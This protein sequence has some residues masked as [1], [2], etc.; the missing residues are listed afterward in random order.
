MTV[1]RP[2]AKPR[3]GRELV[4]AAFFGPV[5]DRLA[6][7]LA[8][9]RVPPPAVVLA[10]AVAGVA[11]ALL[12][13]RGAFVA[14]A[15]VL[16]LKTVLDNADGRLARVSRRVTLFGRYLDT[17]ADL[18]VNA[19]FFAALGSATG[20]PW[21]ALAAFVALTLVLSANHV[22]NELYREAR[23]DRP[24]P[25]PRSGGFAERAAE[26]AYRVVFAPQDR[27]LRAFHERRLERLVASPADRTGS[28]SST[29]TATR[30]RFSPTSA[31]RP[32]SSF[33]VCVSLPGRRRSTSGSPSARP[34]CYPF[35]SFVAS[36]SCVDASA[37][38]G[39]AQ[40]ETLAVH[41]GGGVGA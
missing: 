33:S 21:L 36:G 18:V 40:D 2:G 3:P 17:E 35:S 37:S 19:A 41:R 1:T 22:A 4:V 30:C 28:G 6:R 38:G 10:N 31:S 5:A 29:T 32:S 20:Q 12:V 26:L 13:Q 16:Q 34:A 23:G 27:L 24:S 15:L 25:L 14:A 8:R 11:A 7:M 9:F 39:S